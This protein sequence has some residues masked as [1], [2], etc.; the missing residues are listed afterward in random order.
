MCRRGRHERLLQEAMSLSQLK[1]TSKK[2]PR[3]SM[4]IEKNGGCNKMT[5]GNCGCFFCWRCNRA[6]DGYDHFGSGSCVLFEQA[7]ITAWERQQ[8]YHAIGRQ[9]IR[10]RARA[11]FDVGGAGGGQLV[12]RS[13][14]GCRQRIP[15]DGRS[16]HMVCWNC[17]NGFC[18]DCGKAIPKGKGAVAKHYMPPSPCKQHS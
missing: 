8:G 6:V 13:C 7:E 15:K 16:N 10:D 12:V 14:P 18:F 3:C 5:C 4:G 11:L 17:M 2:C 1:K 9:N